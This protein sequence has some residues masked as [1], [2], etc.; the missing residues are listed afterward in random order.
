MSEE[1]YLQFEDAVKR[2]QQLPDRPDYETML[3]LYSLYKQAT[4]GDV[5]GIRPRLTDYVGRVK[6][7]AWS[8]LDGQSRECAMQ[9]Y[10]DLV[11]RL[12]FGN[13]S[14]RTHLAE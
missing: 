11:D 7:D 14:A 3:R 12:E 8:K 5:S 1:I 9:A 2:V 6:Y 10:I 13:K 4:V